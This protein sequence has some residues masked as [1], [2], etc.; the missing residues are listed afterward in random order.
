MRPGTK[1]RWQ[2]GL[3]NRDGRVAGERGLRNRS[4]RIELDQMI[5]AETRLSRSP[6]R[7]AMRSRSR[8]P[9]TEFDGMP[10]AIVEADRLDTRETLERPG[11]ANR[12]ILPA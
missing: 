5:V 3:G 1:V 8:V 6:F 7:A 10:L 4:E 2:T 11:E 12:R 9:H